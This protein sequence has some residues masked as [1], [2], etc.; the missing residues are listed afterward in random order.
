MEMEILEGKCRVKVQGHWAIGLG[1]KN[2][3]KHC[4]PA[5]SNFTKLNP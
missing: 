1:K 3:L 5:L 4:L 2:K